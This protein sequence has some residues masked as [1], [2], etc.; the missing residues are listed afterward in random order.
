MGVENQ[1]I[2]VASIDGFGKRKDRPSHTLFNY[3][4]KNVCTTCNN[5]WMSELENWFKRHL[6]LLVEPT[7]ATLA[8]EHIK[9]LLPESGMLAAWC[10]KTALTMNNN[11]LQ[12]TINDDEMVQGLCLNYIVNDVY[13]DMAHIAKPDVSHIMSKGFRLGNGSRFAKWETRGDGKAYTCI[14]QLNHLALRVYRCPGADP[15]YRTKL[16]RIPYR[17]F[18]ASVIDPHAVDYRF[19]TLRDFEDSLVL[20]TEERIGGWGIRAQKNLHL[21]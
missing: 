15:F 21:R 6:G 17:L 14:I 11:S 16:K 4:T 12:K 9:I 2:A 13:V 1:K 8:N 18:P 19:D 5:G 7:W 10:L 3:T 20:N